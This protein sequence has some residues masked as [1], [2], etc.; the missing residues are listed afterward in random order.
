[1]FLFLNIYLSCALSLSS[2]AVGG[3]TTQTGLGTCTL[4]AHRR[5]PALSAA[6]CLIP[7]AFQSQE[8]CVEGFFC[9][10]S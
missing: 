1:M 8:R 6:L 3:T 5:T 2:N 10:A 7:A 4:I 9:A